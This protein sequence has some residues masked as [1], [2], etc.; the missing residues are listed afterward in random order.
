ML[1]VKEMKLKLSFCQR[2]RTKG[3]GDDQ[4]CKLIEI[5]RKIFDSYSNLTIS[6]RTPT[7]SKKFQ[8]KNINFNSSR[9][10]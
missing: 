5:A 8:A 10:T 4:G 7:C 1:Q 2:I 3:N 9:S 6:N